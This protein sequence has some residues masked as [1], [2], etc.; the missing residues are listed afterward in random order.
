MT[1]KQS[2]AHQNYNENVHSGQG[3]KHTNIHRSHDNIAHEKDNVRGF[4]L[5]I[6][7]IYLFIFLT[8][9]YV[10]YLPLTFA[11]SIFWYILIYLTESTIV[12]T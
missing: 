1:L 4:Y 12:S 8:R 7:F 11:K 5:F 10:N 6:Y 3:Y 2:Q 9:I